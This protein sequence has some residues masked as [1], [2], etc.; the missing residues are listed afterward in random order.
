MT[1]ADDAPQGLRPDVTARLTHALATAQRQRRL[2][3]VVAGLVRRGRLAWSGGR[4][5]LPGGTPPD[6]D[7]QYRI[8]S[9][10]KT[11]TAALVLRL[12]DEGALALGDPLERHLPGT[13]F[14]DRTIRDLLSHQAGVPAERPGPWWERTPGGDAADLAARLADQPAANEPGERFHYSNVG[15]GL[16]GE[17]VARHRGHGWADAVAAEL[18]TPLGMRRTTTRPQDPAAPGLAVHPW[19][20][21]VLPEPEHDAGAMAPAGQLWST[22]ADLATWAAVLA[23]DGG[24]VLDGDTVEEMRQPVAIEPGPGGFAGY[25]LG[26]ETWWWRDRAVVGHGGSMPGFRAILVADPST[27]DAVVVLSNSTDGLDHALAIDLLGLVDDLDP[28]LPD[29]WTPG[30]APA[31]D[32]LDLLGTWHWGPAP[33]VMRALGPDLLRLDGLDG[34]GRS[35]RFR[36]AGDGSWTGLDGYYAGEVLRPARA[37]D[38]RVTHLEVATFVLTRTPYDP[39]AP[40]PGGVDPDGWRPGP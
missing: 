32:V 40:I 19:A 33:L 11:F 29:V 7:V 4:G 27:Q 18:L 12:R 24:D 34:P 17:V 1:T 2:P 38:G 26:L 28:A 39:A 14:G 9:I 36:A 30:P 16:L 5:T 8:G 3:S 10:S 37:A 22:V 6:E 20:D 23:G 35:S 25:G 21:L 15:Y 13:P 31:P